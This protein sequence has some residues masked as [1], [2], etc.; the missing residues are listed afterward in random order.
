VAPEVAAKA[1][2][3]A[4]PNAAATARRIRFFMIPTPSDPATAGVVLRCK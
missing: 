3:A 4:T 1:A 2:M